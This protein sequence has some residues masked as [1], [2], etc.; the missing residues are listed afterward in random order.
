MLNELIWADY[1]ILGIIGLSVLIGVWR[2]FMREVLSLA[3]WIAAFLISFVFAETAAAYLTDYISVPSVRTVVAFGGLFLVT[4]F[5]GGLINILVAQM[6]EST[7]LSGTDRM[8]GVVFGVLRGVAIVAI[9]V[10]LAGLTPVPQDPWWSQSLFLP[11]FQQL[12]LWLRDFLPPGVAEN[13]S[14]QVN[15]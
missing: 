4:L 15:P 3:A 14:F 1:A 2:G 12:A 11:H 9:L 6:I 7:G 8:I 5:I 13:I 10:L